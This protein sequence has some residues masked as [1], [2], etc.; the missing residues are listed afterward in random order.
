MYWICKDTIPDYESKKHH[1]FRLRQ[2]G[3]AM[4]RFFILLIIVVGLAFF[5]KH[6]LNQSKEPSGR[7]RWNRSGIG[8]FIGL[9]GSKLNNSV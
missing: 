9:L 2:K 6:L 4:N 1:Y 7:C 5:Y 8:W 3:Q